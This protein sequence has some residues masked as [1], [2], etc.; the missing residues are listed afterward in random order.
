[1]LHGKKIRLSRIMHHHSRRMLLVPLDH[2]VT[3]G[4]VE[5]LEDPKLAVTEMADGG[6]DAVELHRGL[7]RHSYTMTHKNTGLI[8]HLSASTNLGP[9]AEVKALVGSVEEALRLGADA[10]AIQV[11][12]GDPYERSML[13][14]FGRVADACTLWGMP[15]LAMMYARGRLVSDSYA[16]EVVVHCARVGA[17]LGADIVKV[18][19]PGHPLDFSKVVEECCVPVLIGGGVKLEN[20]RDFLQMAYDSVLAGG[21]GLSVGR[22]IFQHTHRVA[23]LR[24]LRSVIHEG[25]NVD[26]ALALMNE[27]SSQDTV[28]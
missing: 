17:E 20:T 6:A 8:M 15:L 2:G 5:G 14:D 13:S 9:N 16:T 12:L 10:V 19:Y 3:F 28:M 1:M 21:A 4:S 24:A 22:N 18:H 11:N 26:E 25:A 27:A 7:I 23:L